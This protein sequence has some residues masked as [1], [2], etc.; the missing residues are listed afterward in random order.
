MGRAGSGP[1]SKAE[2]M[3]EV[4]VT[5]SGIVKGMALAGLLVCGAGQRAGAIEFRLQDAAGRE[6]RAENYKGRPIFLEFGA[7]W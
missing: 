7:C 5:V 6:V 2:S 4:T 1:A 3:M